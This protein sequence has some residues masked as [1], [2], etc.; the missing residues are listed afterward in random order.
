MSAA[1]YC[2]H[3]LPPVSTPVLLTL[4]AICHRRRWNRRQVAAGI[5][6]IGGQQHKGN[7]WQNLTPVSL[8]PAAICHRFCH[9][10]RWHQWCTLTCEYLREFS[11]KFEITLLL[12]SGAWGKVMH[13]KNLKQKIS[14]HCPFKRF[15]FILNCL[16]VY[17]EKY[18]N[19]SNE[20]F[21]LGTACTTPA[22]L[23]SFC[24]DKAKS[25]PEALGKANAVFFVNLLRQPIWRKASIP[26]KTSSS[27]N[28]C[29][30]DR[31]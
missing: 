9:R 6:D 15:T 21:T 8:I 14:W 26:N 10:C 22:K 31:F 18:L 27:V 16:K 24:L 4:V 20:H 5:V 17:Q 11:K 29:G 30:W 23:Y 12:F 3:Y 2:S 25:S 1:W 13:E 7:W 19:Q 28:N